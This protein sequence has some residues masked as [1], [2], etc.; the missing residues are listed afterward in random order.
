MQ[1]KRWA[2]MWL[3]WYDGWAGGRASAGAAEPVPMRPNERQDL[4]LRTQT[5]FKTNST[6]SRKLKSK[7]IE[8][9]LTNRVNQ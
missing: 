9:S 6:F 3:N 7:S 4:N 5:R 1:D 8:I 2:E